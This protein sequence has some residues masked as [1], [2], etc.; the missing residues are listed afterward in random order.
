MIE[1]MTTDFLDIEIVW[2]TTKTG[3]EMIS[4]YTRNTYNLPY[5]LDKTLEKAIMTTGPDNEEVLKS[6]KL[7]RAIDQFHC[8]Y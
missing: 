5:L 2:R 6:I 1:R 7:T 3:T 4:K 8:S